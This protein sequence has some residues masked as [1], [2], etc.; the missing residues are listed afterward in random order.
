MDADPVA[1]ALEFVAIPDGPPLARLEYESVAEFEVISRR[2][3]LEA[4]SEFL[5]I[6]VRLGSFGSTMVL[7]AEGSSLGLERASATT[8]AFPWM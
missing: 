4:E 6:V 3:W 7:M 2:S 8:L 1:D 5:D